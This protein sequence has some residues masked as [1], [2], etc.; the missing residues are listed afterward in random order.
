MSKSP[1]TTPRKQ[2]KWETY[3]E[4]ARDILAQIVTGFD[5]ELVEGKQKLA[6][7]T[8]TNWEIDAKGVRADDKGIVVVECRRHGSTLD[9]KQVAAL[10]FAIEDVGASGGIIVSPLG[11]QKGG[12]IVA[13]AKNIV[14]VQ[15]DPLSTRERWIAEIGKVIQSGLTITACAMSIATL[16]M[17]VKRADGTIE[18]LGTV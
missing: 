7:A 14:C 3:E 13:A 8:G 10:A 11:V 18:D 15:L 2:K 17:V 9:Q 12:R 5:L 16:G 6:G 1:S 4:V